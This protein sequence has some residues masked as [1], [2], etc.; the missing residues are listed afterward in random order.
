MRFLGKGTNV[1]LVDLTIVNQFLSQS[2]DKGI[3][4]SGRSSAS[5]HVLCDRASYCATDYPDRWALIASKKVHFGS[6]SISDVHYFW[7]FRHPPTHLQAIFANEG[8]VSMRIF[9]GLHIKKPPTL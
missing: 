4:Q 8:C 2:D 1:A 6:A 5:L 9:C 7:H 3:G